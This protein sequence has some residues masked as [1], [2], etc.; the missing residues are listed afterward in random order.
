MRMLSAKHYLI[1]I[2]Y[3]KKKGN[4]SSTRCKDALCLCASALCLSYRVF[5][6]RVI[7]SALHL[8]SLREAFRVARNPSTINF[9]NHSPILMAHLSRDPKWIPP[10]GEKEGGKGVARLVRFPVIDACAL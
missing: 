4:Y 3:I 5:L 9:A 7:I 1:P 6:L 10:F 2:V 8:F